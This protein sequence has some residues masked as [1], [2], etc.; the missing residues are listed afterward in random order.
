MRRRLLLVP[1]PFETT[2][3][4]FGIAAP[5]RIIVVRLHRLR[6]LLIINITNITGRRFQGLIWYSEKVL[7]IHVAS[8]RH[9]M[10]AE[11]GCNLGLTVSGPFEGEGLA[12]EAERAFAEVSPIAVDGVSQVDQGFLWWD[13]AE[14]LWI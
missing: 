3:E 6:M 1:L 2:L 11:S 5:R 4:R 9:L 12:A 10:L 13:F 8:V 14:V 7:P